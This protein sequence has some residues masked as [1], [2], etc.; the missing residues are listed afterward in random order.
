MLVQLKLLTTV[1]MYCHSRTTSVCSMCMHRMPVVLS[2]GATPVLYAANVQVTCEHPTHYFV[3]QPENCF[4]TFFSQLSF[5][6]FSENTIVSMIIIFVCAV[7]VFIVVS[8]LVE[9]R[10]EEMKV[11]VFGRLG[12]Q[13]CAEQSLPQY[14]SVLQW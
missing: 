5:I 13:M 9:K 3:Q 11:C 1:N 4:S 14:Y 7:E 8:Q 6:P 2:N 12:T 10:H